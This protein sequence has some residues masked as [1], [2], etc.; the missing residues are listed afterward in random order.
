MSGDLP[1]VPAMNRNGVVFAGAVV[2]AFL[3]VLTLMRASWSIDEHFITR[4]EFQ[5]VSQRL[6]GIEQQLRRLEATGGRR[7]R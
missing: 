6:D 3:F 4:R 2:I 7:G 1:T 5:E